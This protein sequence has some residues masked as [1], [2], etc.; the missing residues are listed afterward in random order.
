MHQRIHLTLSIL[1]IALLAG[2]GGIPLLP[3]SPSLT[4]APSATGTPVTS[5]TAHLAP[6]PAQS[7]N[8]WLPPQFDPAA[9][10]PAATLLKE[11]LG[12]FTALHPGLIIQV[13]LKA[14]SG[15]AS[16]LE[17][18]IAANNAAPAAQPDLVLLRRADLESAALKGVLH[19]LDGLTTALDDPDWFAYARQL[20]GFQNTTFGLPF[21]GDALVLVYR[22][23]AV[24]RLEP[25]WEAVRRQ[26][27]R[28]VFPAADPQALFSLS[29]YLSTG[30]A[31]ANDQ[32]RSTLDT[33]ALIQLLTFYRQNRLEGRISSAVLQYQD[34]N[35][36]WQAYR[37]QRAS[38]VVTWASRYLGEKPTDSAIIPLP[39]LEQAPFTLAS[40]W[41]W[42]LAGSEAKKRPLAV[43]LAE[44]LVETDFLSTWSAAGGHLPTRPSSL[45]SWEDES[46]Q[47]LISEICQSAQLAPSQELLV[48][49]GPALQEAAA[50]VLKGFQS[51][52]NA[53]QALLEGLE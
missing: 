44:F 3:T 19:P 29:L 13:R 25:D 22:P 21:A 53:A 4:P 11:R 48:N 7:L 24:G 37:A 51:P 33:P 20:A 31:L 38:A 10:T 50:D 15:T 30:A 39:G 18:L 40:G 52:E 9:G 36:A 27:A 46:Q 17:S 12:E 1:V 49:L 45:S 42:S 34:D 28:L 2:C 14:E 43:E 23:S 35:Q 47:A 16:L 32:G 8:I 5:Q 6:T 26:R 41:V